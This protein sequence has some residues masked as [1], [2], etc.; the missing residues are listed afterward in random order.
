MLQTANE[1]TPVKTGYLRSQNYV[2]VQS[3]EKVEFGNTTSYAGYV[4]FGTNKQ[5][6]QPFWEAIL[7]TIQQRFKERYFKKL[8]DLD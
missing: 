3:D 4:H 1:N 5:Q 6:A 7:D 2:E 8:N